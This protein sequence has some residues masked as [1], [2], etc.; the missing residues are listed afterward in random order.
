MTYAYTV[1][2][3]DGK[4]YGPADLEALKA[5][6]A[7]GRIGPDTLVWREGA[8][9]WR[10][11]TEV[12]ETGELLAE[13]ALGATVTVAPR[14]SPAAPAVPAAAPLPAAAPGVVRPATP[15]RSHPAGPTR[16]A[17]RPR[18]S[19]LRIVI[20]LAIVAAL[21]AGGLL[22]WR[23]GQ[24]TRD[25]ERAEAGIRAYALPDRSY[26]DELLG[27][28][29]DLPEGWIVL[30][31]DS[32]FFHA[33]DAKLRLAHP[34]L[35]A[36][37]RLHVQAQARGRGDRSLDATLARALE[38]WRLFSAGLQEQGRVDASVGGTP[39]RQANV[40]WE[41]DGQQIRGMAIVWHDGWN[42]FAL[43]A[44]GPA[45]SEAEVNTATSSLVSQLQMAGVAAA[46]IRSAADAIAPAIPELSRASVEALVEGRLAAGEP[47]DDLPQTSL[48]VVSRGLRALT[49]Q[50]SQEMGQI[51]AQVYKPLKEK[52]RARLAAW[53]GQVRARATSAPEEGQAM[54]QALSDGLLALPEDLR[55]RLQALNEK[56]VT[57]ALAQP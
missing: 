15:V 41:A 50:E 3:A 2:L 56:A 47:T 8:T 21:L 30:R 44:W 24:P 40:S 42:E 14:P 38:D 23:A 39:A 10:P 16:T 33:P 48:R 52:E 19:P 43:L 57:A 11:L 55:A 17:R 45:A 5:W 53:L 37:G 28:R 31:P 4:E 18:P 49:G 25:R 35:R 13:V 51:Y 20:P 6:M 1:R 32:P 9:D 46:R 54:R 29:L 12:L 27:L 26:A 22:W 34:R 7:E 36:F